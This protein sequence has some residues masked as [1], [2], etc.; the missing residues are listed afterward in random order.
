M[1]VSCGRQVWRDER[2]SL[3]NSVRQKAIQIFGTGVLVL[4]WYCYVWLQEVGKDIAIR[5]LL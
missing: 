4:R 1:I 3:L 5:A 2:Q